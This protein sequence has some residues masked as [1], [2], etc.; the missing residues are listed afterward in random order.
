MKTGSVAA[1]NKGIVAQKMVSNQAFEIITDLWIQGSYD[2][3]EYTTKSAV[4]PS[5]R[6]Q[7]PPAINIC[8]KFSSF[9]DFICINFSV[10][11]TSACTAWLKGSRVI[12]FF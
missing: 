3:N 1:K 9:L 12:S 7:F 8:T 2:P 6:I 4:N 5:I 10:G 11:N